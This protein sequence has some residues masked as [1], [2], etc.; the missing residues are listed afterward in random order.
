MSQ[1]NHSGSFAERYENSI[2]H[3]QHWSNTKIAQIKT[4]FD[5]EQIQLILIKRMVQA[6]FPNSIFLQYM[7]IPKTSSNQILKYL[8]N[9]QFNWFEASSLQNQQV[10]LH[11][12]NKDNHKNVLIN[13]SR[14]FLR[15]DNKDKHPS[16][17]KKSRK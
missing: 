15:I 17:G 4:I 11:A 6:C 8:S 7:H 2:H 10:H 9:N 16:L 14:V 13:S 12:T 5:L 3:Q 1:I